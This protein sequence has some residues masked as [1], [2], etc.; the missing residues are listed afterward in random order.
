[1]K[2]IST[3]LFLSAWLLL[4][5]HTPLSANEARFNSSGFAI[6]P[7]IVRESGEDYTALS[8]FLEPSDGFAPNVNVRKIYFEGTMSEF[9]ESSKNDFEKMEWEVLDSRLLDDGSML[10]EATGTYNNLELHWYL[11]A[12]RSREA[13]YLATGTTLQSQWMDVGRII[14]RSADSIRTLRR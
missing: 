9:L 13:F 1:M 7:L 11:R 12:V 3:L 6:E 5:T 14:R 4:S 8:M 10:L 2:K